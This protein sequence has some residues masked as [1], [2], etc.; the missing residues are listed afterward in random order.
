MD[1]TRKVQRLR[2]GALPGWVAAEEEEEGFTE[3]L[4]ARAPP[5]EGEEGEDEERG[6]EEE[7]DEYVPAQ[8]AHKEDRRLMRLQQAKQVAQE[9]RKGGGRRRAV[10]EAEVIT[11]G[12]D[13]EEEEEEEP[14]DEEAGAGARRRRGVRRHEQEEEGEEEEL[15]TGDVAVGGGGGGEEDDDEDAIARRRAAIRERLKN[16]RMEEAAAAK[17]EEEESDEEDED[18]ESEYETDTDESDDGIGGGLFNLPKPVF[19]PKHKRELVKEQER[20]EREEIERARLKELAKE[21]RKRETRNLVAEEVRKEA[22]GGEQDLADGYN[23]DT[24]APDDTDKP[25]DD[26]LEF[27]SWRLR[28]LFRIKRD[29]DLRQARAKEK[30]EVERRRKMTDEERAAEDA[31]LGINKG[32]Q[33]GEK[34]KGKWKFM[35]KYYHKGAFYMD[36]ESVAKGGKDDVR[37]RAAD[38]ATGEDKFNKA[39]L[40]SVMQVKKFGRAGQTKYTHLLDQDTMRKVR[41][42]GRVHVDVCI[43]VGVGI[44]FIYFIFSFLTR[45]LTH[46]FTNNTGEATRRA[47]FVEGSRDGPPEGGGG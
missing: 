21:Q 22:E 45:I 24:G 33:G 13:E 30:A 12:D 18:D 15:V 1:P 9:A 26:A 43:C 14:Q 34:D 38:E 39:S 31:R 36:E 4:S 46:L 27:E 47:A 10:Y 19:I 44:F 3:R 37:R 23:S 32:A 40:P 7:D 42:V 29:R 28:E 17:P 41:M 25:E 8:P 2:P 16:L 20:E 11:G 35:Q 6:R 5:P